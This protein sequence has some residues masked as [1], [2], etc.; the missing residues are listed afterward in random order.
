MEI[1]WFLL[2]VGC[3]GLII[4]V[5]EDDALEIERLEEQMEIEEDDLWQQTR[6]WQL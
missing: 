1:D 6:G 2:F 5:V 4:I 3:V